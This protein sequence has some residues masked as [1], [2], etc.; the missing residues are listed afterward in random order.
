MYTVAWSKKKEVIFYSA[1]SFFIHS[2]IP[3]L[4]FT[5]IHW[6]SSVY[7]AE[8]IHGVLTRTLRQQLEPKPKPHDLARIRSH[9]RILSGTE[10]DR[11]PIVVER[12]RPHRRLRH[13]A[14]SPVRLHLATFI[15]IRTVIAN[16]IVARRLLRSL[17]IRIGS[18]IG[19]APT[20]PSVLVV[21]IPNGVVEFH[22]R[23]G[24]FFF[25]FCCGLVVVVVLWTGGGGV[26]DWW[27]WLWVGLMV[28]WLWSCGWWC[29]CFFFFLW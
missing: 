21:E 13:G 4:S 1:L 17:P 14:P 24:I 23:F 9:R 11:P 27:W 29:G 18:Q 5:L 15:C 20:K 28:E 16:R 2:L 19:P 25:S 3:T 22:W 26:V 10:T 6:S 7:L 8:N 12:G